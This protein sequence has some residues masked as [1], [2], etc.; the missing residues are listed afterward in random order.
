MDEQTAVAVLL[1]FLMSIIILALI[2]YVIQIIAYWKIFTKAG[3]PGWKSI[4]PVYNVFIQ[5]KLTWN[6]MMFWVV[7]GLIIVGGI[8][9]NIPVGLIAGIGGLLTLA[10]TVIN[11]VAYHKLS[12]AFGHGVGFTIG[13]IFLNP[14]F[15]LILGFGSSQYK[16]PQ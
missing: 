1:S 14:I 10:G 9:S 6:P 15:I 2:Y 8:L 5:Y 12:T 3:E 13:L 11:L 16:G 4:I 7:F